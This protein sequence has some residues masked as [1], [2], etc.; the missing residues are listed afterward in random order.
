MG[1]STVHGGALRPVKNPNILIDQSEGA[2]LQDPI[3]NNPYWWRTAHEK[4]LAKALKDKTYVVSMEDVDIMEAWSRIRSS[5]P[6]F[7]NLYDTGVLLTMMNRVFGAGAAP[8]APSDDHGFWA[9]ASQKVMCDAFKYD[10]GEWLTASMGDR[11]FQ[12]ALQRFS[13]SSLGKLQKPV[14]DIILVRLGGSIDDGRTCDF[15]VVISE[16]DSYSLSW[17]TTWPGRLPE[18]LGIVNFRAQLVKNTG[19]F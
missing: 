6:I 15:P 3:R 1:G 9:N 19:D 4:E 8:P 12:A 10:N 7:T 16:K 18:S 14:L 5:K 2:N 13:K 11:S 17:W